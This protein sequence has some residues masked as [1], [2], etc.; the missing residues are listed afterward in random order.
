MQTHTTPSAH[1]CTAI[2]R[3]P[4]TVHYLPRQK[5]DATAVH[6][7]VPGRFYQPHAL[8]LPGS[9]ERGHTP[10]VGIECSKGGA[11]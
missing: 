3:T 4:S 2:D 9:A 6:Y 11:A 1:A 10:I 7:L 5:V 8:S